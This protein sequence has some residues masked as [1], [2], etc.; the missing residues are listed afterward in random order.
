MHIRSPVRMFLCHSPK[1]ISKS[2]RDWFHETK[3]PWAMVLSTVHVCRSLNAKPPDWIVQFHFFKN[4]WH[5]VVQNKL[6]PSWSRNC[7]VTGKHTTPFSL[8]AGA[9]RKIFH[10]STTKCD[11]NWCMLDALECKSQELAG[12]PNIESNFWHFT[13]IHR[14]TFHLYV[15]VL[16]FKFFCFGFYIFFKKIT[17][18]NDYNT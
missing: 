5:V 7:F 3:Y 9:Y 11:K 12:W 4:L 2:A 17:V 13:F 14:Q 8:V 15:P 16:L 6:M 1:E 18:G 10:W